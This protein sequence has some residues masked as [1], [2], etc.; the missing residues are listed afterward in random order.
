MITVNCELKDNKWYSLVDKAFVDKAGMTKV[1]KGKY[2]GNGISF[3]NSSF[4]AVESL[5]KMK[6]FIESVKLFTRNVNGEEED[7]FEYYDYLV[8]T[9]RI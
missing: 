1:S 8:S 6:G 4:D 5:L 2:E 3:F 7:V 9:G